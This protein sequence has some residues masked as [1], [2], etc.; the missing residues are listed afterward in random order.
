M[1]HLAVCFQ[2]ESQSKNFMEVNVSL[3]SSTL[4]LGANGSM[5][6]KNSTRAEPITEPIHVKWTENI[7]LNHI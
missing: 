7:T 2:Q 5:N 6:L 1:T 3:S 4:F